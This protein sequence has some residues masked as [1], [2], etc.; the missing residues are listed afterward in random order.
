MPI[1]PDGRQ[2]LRVELTKEQQDAIR[3]YFCDELASGT[4]FLSLVLKPRGY[5]DV[6]FVTYHEAAAP[7]TNSTPTPTPHSLTELAE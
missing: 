3:F 1:M 5:L 4:G 6:H 7:L 2:P